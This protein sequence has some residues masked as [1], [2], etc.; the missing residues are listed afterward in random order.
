MRKTLLI[1]ILLIFFK[2]YSQIAP[3]KYFVRFTDKNDSPYSVNHPEEFLTQRAIDRRIRQGIAVV[4]NDIP[5]NPQYLQGVADEGAVLLNVTKWL[6][7]VTIFTESQSVLDS[8]LALPYVEHVLKLVDRGIPSHKKSFFENETYKEFIPDGQLTP[9]GVDELAYGMSRHQI[10]QI[11][12]IPLHNLGYQGQGMVIAVLDGGFDGV[13]EHPVFDSLWEKN[14]ILGTKDFVHPHDQDVFT[15][16]EHGKSVL[17]TMGANLPGQMIGTAPEAS[18]WLLRSEDVNSENIIEEYNWV[19][20]AE[21]ADS[22]GADV[23]NS[24]LSYRDF[25]LPQWDHS[26]EDLDG[27]TAVATRGADYAASKGILVCNSAGNSAG[28]DFPWNAAPAD[29]DSVLSI[30]AV[31]SGG[32]WASFS[33]VGPTVDGRIKPAVAAMGQGTTVAR[34]TSSVGTG[35]GTS[36]SSPIITGMS[37]C[38]WQANP[39]MKVMEIQAAI[40]ASASHAETPNDTIG[41]GI[42][43]YMRAH[44]IMTEIENQAGNLQELVVSLSPN[45]FKDVLYLR[46]AQSKEKQAEIELY[47][48]LGVLLFR[49]EISINGTG[50]IEIFKNKLSWI[51]SGIYFLRISSGKQ[52]ITKKVV[53]Q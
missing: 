45:P 49:E 38:L 12:G 39:S 32:S 42:P 46:F 22:V 4:E 34:G 15:E 7:G 21:Y 51:K 41:W 14:Q 9:N 40:K 35:N 19:S 29:A 20:A 31:T 23:I 25:D 52:L 48:I 33:S 1:I 18:Y 37:A 26:Y 3:D 50:T 24:S 36:Y 43:D 8:V 30:G 28:G 53:R 13:P 6:N 11:N 27:N 44:T 5:V 17:S 47:N 16:S 2:G 10:D